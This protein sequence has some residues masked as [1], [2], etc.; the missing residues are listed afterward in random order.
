MATARDPREVEPKLS[1][2]QQPQTHPDSN[3]ELTR[4]AEP[5]FQG[6]IDPEGHCTE[7]NR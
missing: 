2:P 6:D 3:G 1:F 5:V 7:I 4:R